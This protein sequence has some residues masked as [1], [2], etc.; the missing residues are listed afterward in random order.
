MTSTQSVIGTKL[1]VGTKA[2]SLTG[3]S[4]LRVGIVE[5]FGEFGDEAEV[6]KFNAA[7]EGKVY[8]SKGIVDPGSMNIMLADLEGDPGRERLEA[9]MGD[10]NAY[11]FKLEKDDAPRDE[12]GL[13]V[14][15]PTTFYFRSLVVSTRRSVGG[16]SDTWK[17]N[18]KLE[19]TESYQ[20]VPAA[21]S[22]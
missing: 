16:S 10:P 20:S 4:Y 12:D 1:Y 15:T 8:K 21:A 3:D 11:N 17:R 7:D 6:I 14:G 22:T 18:L 19:L 2:V 13:I 5:N 9:A